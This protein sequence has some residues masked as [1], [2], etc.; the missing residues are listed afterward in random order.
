VDGHVFF[1]AYYLETAE[2]HVL[3]I[4]ASGHNWR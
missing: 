4:I 3:E 2:V 1:Y